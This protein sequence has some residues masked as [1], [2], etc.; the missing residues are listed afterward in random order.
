MGTVQSSFVEF[1]TIS[2]IDVHS[3]TEQKIE[4]IVLDFH[5]HFFCVRSDETVWKRFIFI[6]AVCY[7]YTGILPRLFNP[8]G[9]HQEE[10]K[11]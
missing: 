6:F 4:G 2:F 3:M 5:S 11:L 10:N 9:V 8:T 7:Q 1:K